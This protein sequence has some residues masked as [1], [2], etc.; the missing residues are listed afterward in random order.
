MHMQ[1]IYLYKVITCPFNFRRLLNLNADP[2][3]WELNKLTNDSTATLFRSFTFIVTLGNSHKL[4]NSPSKSI[5]NVFNICRYQ[6]H[7]IFCLN[8]SPLSGLLVIRYLGD[9]QVDSVF[10]ITATATRSSRGSFFLFFRG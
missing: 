10:L 9:S 2:K 5:I 4:A 1:T 6:Y 3:N 8:F 7:G